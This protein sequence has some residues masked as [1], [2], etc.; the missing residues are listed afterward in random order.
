A[1]DRHPS[2][3]ARLSV[4]DTAPSAAAPLYRSTLTMH[5]H[6]PETAHAD[7]GSLQARHLQPMRKNYSSLRPIESSAMVFRTRCSFAY[8]LTSK[9]DAMSNEISR[10]SFNRLLG[11]GAAVAAGL[12]PFGAAA[13]E[14]ITVLNWQGY[15]TDEPWALKAFAEKT[16]IT[17]NHDYFNAEAEMLT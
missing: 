1:G 16:G 6:G 12:A 14:T 5:Q 8:K 15:G 13:K 3:V 10:C 17:V 9:G 11:T 4:C 7:G 2:A